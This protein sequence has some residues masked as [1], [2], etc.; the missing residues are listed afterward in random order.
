MDMTGSYMLLACMHAQSAWRPMII[1]YIDKNIA[2]T[3]YNTYMYICIYAVYNIYQ[4]TYI[5]TRDAT[6][7]NF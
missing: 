6:I 5:H 7:Q 3:D 1:N 4:S 2:H